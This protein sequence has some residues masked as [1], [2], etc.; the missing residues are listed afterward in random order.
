MGSVG[1]THSTLP[2]VQ[3]RDVNSATNIRH[4]LVEM[5]LGHKRPASLEVAEAGAQ[6]VEARMTAAV[7]WME[8]G[9]ERLCDDEAMEEVEEVQDE[10][11][12]AEAAVRCGF[13]AGAGR[14]EGGADGGGGA[15]A[16][17]VAVPAVSDSWLYRQKVEGR[18]MLANS[19]SPTRATCPQLGPG[20]TT[21]L[22]LLQPARQS[23]PGHVHNTLWV[24][25]GD[26]S[27]PVALRTIAGQA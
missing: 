10:E 8:E 2:A 11:S 19:T 15:C 3:G 25:K 17:T 13:W 14:G 1:L 21:V 22:T 6:L 20:P 12:E 9:E 7:A 18:A 5:Q 4:E 27:P 23:C 24:M 26:S 16:C